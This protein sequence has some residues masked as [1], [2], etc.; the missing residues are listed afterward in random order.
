MDAP[1]SVI[2]IVTAYN[3]GDRLTATVAALRDA[4]PGARIVVADDHSTDD[5]PAVVAAAGVELVRAEKNLGK[6]G[7]A[8]LAARRVLP[9]V[10]VDDPPVVLLCDGDLAAT[11]HQLPA[12]VEAVASGQCELAVA[13]FA[14][15]VGG[16]FGFAVGYARGAIRRLCGLETTAPISGQRALRGDVLPVVV[17]FAPRFGMEIGMTVDAVRAGFT[18]GEVE[19]DLTHRATGRT[20]QGF[21]HRGKQLKDFVLVEISRR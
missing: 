14:K 13:T 3:E 17:P 11:A 4:F 8:T 12:L 5:T 7:V 10:L 18:V 2:A 6:G 21:L 20:L 19:L 1:P 16:G 9:A 15:K